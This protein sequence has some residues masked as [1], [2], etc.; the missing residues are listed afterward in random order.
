MAYGIDVD[1]MNATVRRETKTAVIVGCG[2]VGIFLARAL[3]SEGY[4]VIGTTRTPQRMRTL[5]QIGV[6]PALVDIGEPSTFAALP[7]QYE[8]LIHSAPPGRMTDSS[9]LRDGTENLI[10]FCNG[11]PLKA[12]MYLSSTSVYGPQRGEWVDENTPCHPTSAHG[13][14][15]LQAEERL[16]EANRAWGLP[17]MI[18][19]L[20]GIYGPGR[21]IADRIKTGTYQIV[22]LPGEPL[23]TN[24]I[25]VED[26]ATVVLAALKKGRPGEI[27]LVADDRPSTAEEYAHFIADLIGAPRPPVTSHEEAF[28]RRGISATRFTESKRCKNGK[29]KS[30]LG[31]T[32]KYPTF[33]EGIAASLSGSMLM[34]SSER[35]A[36]ADNVADRHEAQ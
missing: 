34:E 17:V 7:H 31:V 16:V 36:V 21:T 18:F 32:L 15:R 6:K 4:Q 23:W 12:F 2:Y 29:I 22:T 19:R 9:E 1:T 35:H 24:R 30:E 14:V 33:R 11:K 13:K 3:I 27:Y 5:E 26:I 8:I 25:H 20:P 28:R 10:A